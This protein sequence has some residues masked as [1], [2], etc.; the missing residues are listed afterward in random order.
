MANFSGSF[1][2]QTKTTH[3]RE[4]I[5]S[6]FKGLLIK[7]PGGFPPIFFFILFRPDDREAGLVT[8]FSVEFL[9]Y[10]RGVDPSP[11]DQKGDSH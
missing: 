7:G 10:R 8:G 6:E 9:A 5:R 1:D 4:I 3:R 2:H 11:Q